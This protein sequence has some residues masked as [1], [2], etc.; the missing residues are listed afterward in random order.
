MR[1]S[2]RRLAQAAA[3]FLL[4]LIGALAGP[5]P[6]RVF[7]ANY[8]VLANAALEWM[9]YEGRMRAQL[10]PA[11]DSPRRATDQVQTDTHLE[12]R[13]LGYE[14]THRTGVS[15]RRDVYIPCALLWAI[16]L[17]APIPAVGKVWSLGIG[18]VAAL[19]VGVL[20]NCALVELLA[21]THAPK[22]YAPTEFSRAITNFVFQCWLTPPGNRIIAPIVLASLL[23][24]LSLPT[25]PE[26]NP[27]RQEEERRE[28]SQVPS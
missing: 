11:P 24:G 16:L 4:V 6:G 28:R 8:C 21:M 22:A 17:A 23:I 27:A 9:D 26:R 14:G 18:T 1:P 12:L 20:S 5:W 7:I 13:A 15:L 2:K 10:H 3:I 19:S 25:P